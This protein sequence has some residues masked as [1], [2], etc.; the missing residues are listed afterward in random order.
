MSIR[1]TL[2]LNTSV[3]PLKR[4]SSEIPSMCAQGGMRPDLII[5]L[6]CTLPVSGTVKWIKKQA[7]RFSY[8][9][10]NE[11]KRE[12]PCRGTFDINITAHPFN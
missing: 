5:T 12:C 11:N 6:D 8:K 4:R 10:M 2:L 1:F 7:F 3:W 9:Q